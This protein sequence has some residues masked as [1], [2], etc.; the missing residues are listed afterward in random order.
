MGVSDA[1]AGFAAEVGAT[2]PVAVSGGRTRWDL[3]GPLPS[4]TRLVVAPAGVIE[5]RPE[6]MTVRVLAGTPV[7]QMEEALAEC[8]QR[9]AL[10]S[11][12]GTVGGALAVGEN[13]LD[14]LSRGPLRA[15]LLQLRYVAHDGRVVKGGAPTVKNVSGFDL[16]RLMVGA[17]GTLG[18]LAEVV[19]RTT[20]RPEADQWLASDDSDPFRVA[21]C[22]LRRATVLWDGCRT[23]A[24]LE[25]HRVDVASLRRAL[26]GSWEEVE[27]PPPLPP[28]R[29]SLAPSELRSLPVD[30]PG[31]FVASVGV[32]TVHASEAQPTRL[33]DTGAR[34]IADRA[35]QLFDPT[36][37]LNPGRDPG[38]R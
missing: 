13:H 22:L 8:G 3:G 27:S 20:P 4:T 14:V 31:S 23:W 10:P 38:R 25:G 21:A 12:G 29:W 11:R 36:G 35:K 30:G 28:F 34:R 6:E 9:S 26:P 2:G 5:C 18:L 7:E 17:L 19:L 33:L 24:H 37:R 32:G 15:S 1:V 16:P